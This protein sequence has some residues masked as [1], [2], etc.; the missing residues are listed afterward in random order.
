[1]STTMRLTPVIGV[2]RSGSESIPHPG[3]EPIFTALA[4]QWESDGRLVPGRAD[5]EW[6]ALVRRYPWSR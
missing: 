1:M 2:Q 4:E 6:T 3:L 5:E